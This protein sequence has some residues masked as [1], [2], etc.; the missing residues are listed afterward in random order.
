LLNLNPKPM[1]EQLTI[2]E[3]LIDAILVLA[4]D[5]YENTQDFINLAKKSEES[6]IDDLISI[7]M[8]YQKQSN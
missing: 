2:R 1:K 5:E 4:G 7:A 6:L 3:K 8:Y